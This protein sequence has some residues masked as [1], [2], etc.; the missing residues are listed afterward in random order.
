VDVIGHDDE[1]MK[2]D[3][4]FGT[5]LIEDFEKELGIAFDLEEAPSF[6][7]GGGYEEGAGLLWGE[8]HYFEV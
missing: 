1:G 5:V 4:A 3:A 7:G 8:R 6:G 2:L